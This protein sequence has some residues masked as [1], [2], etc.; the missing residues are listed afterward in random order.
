MISAL[1]TCSFSEPT[2]LSKINIIYTFSFSER[3]LL[4]SIYQVD[5]AATPNG[6]AS[7]KSASEGSVLDGIRDVVGGKV[8]NSFIV[9]WHLLSSTSPHRCS[10]SF[11]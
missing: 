8:H 10:I 6:A 5:A 2:Y 7:Q 9:V 11:S 4:F 1:S 3:T